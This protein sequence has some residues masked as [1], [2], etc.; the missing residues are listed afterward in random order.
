VRRKE[1]LLSD[2]GD[3]W[4]KAD[5]GEWIGQCRPLS[6]S[7]S[8]LS[9]TQAGQSET[10][11]AQSN[12]HHLPASPQQV[13]LAMWWVGLRLPYLA[14]RLPRF[15]LMLVPTPTDELDPGLYL[16]PFLGQ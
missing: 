8:V 2:G 11:A 3:G 16:A 10:G 14:S 1:R 6:I 4:R 12:R 9:T 15:C 13:W 5:G 7:D